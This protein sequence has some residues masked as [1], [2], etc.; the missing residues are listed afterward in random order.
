MLHDGLQQLDGS[1]S[2]ASVHGQRSEID[3]SVA[4][5]F[6]DGQ[7]PAIRIL[8]SLDVAEPLEGDP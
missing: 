4:H 3:A 8:R 1:V 7:G 6:I 5:A 2:I